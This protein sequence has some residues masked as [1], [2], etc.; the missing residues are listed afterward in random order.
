MSSKASA[1][2]ITMGTFLPVFTTRP[3]LYTGVRLCTKARNT[4]HRK[5]RNRTTSHPQCLRWYA[6]PLEV[7]RTSGHLVGRA[8]DDKH[9]NNCQTG[10]SSDRT[11]RQTTYACWRAF[12]NFHSSRERVNLYARPRP[13]DAG[14]AYRVGTYGSGLRKTGFQA[15]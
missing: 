10:G 1:I 4:E 11:P 6:R 14:S 8:A 12:Q 5:R 7:R 2:V 15:R 9:G 3:I 13:C